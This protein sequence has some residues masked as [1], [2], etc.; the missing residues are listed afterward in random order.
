MVQM[1]LQTSVYNRIEEKLTQE[2]EERKEKERAKIQS[3][4]RD[5][6]G[7]SH[8]ETMEERIRGLNVDSN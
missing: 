8:R 5:D 2:E 4:G 7:R 3:I 1:I 6:V